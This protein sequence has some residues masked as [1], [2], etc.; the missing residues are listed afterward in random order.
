MGTLRRELLNHIIVLNQG[1][2]EELLR[3]YIEKYY[4]VARPHQGL[5]GDTPV[6]SNQPE[7]FDGSSKLISFPACG[8]MH[9]RYERVA[10]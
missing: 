1:H 4:E 3:E 8:G 6:P 2:L 5:A 9:H 7:K 10:A